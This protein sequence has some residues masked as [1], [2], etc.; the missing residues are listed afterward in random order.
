MAP[1]KRGMGKSVHSSEQRL[2]GELMLQAREKAGLTQQR[3]A[4][5]LKKPQ[6]FVA[7]YEGGERRLDVVEFV[8]VVRAMGG[9]PV[10]ILK[11]LIRRIG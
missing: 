3:L 7:K 1:R 6:S 4:D 5:R 10:R 9:D 8:A 2:F 11:S